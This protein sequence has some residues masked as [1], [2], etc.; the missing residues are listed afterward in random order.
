LKSNG[1][2]HSPPPLNPV[3]GTNV[4]CTMGDSVGGSKMVCCDVGNGVGSCSCPVGAGETLG[5]GD[6]D[7]AGLIVGAGEILGSG[8]IDGAAL[9]V[10][11]AEILGAF[12]MDGGS[13]AGSNTSLGWVEGKRLG[14]VEDVGLDVLVLGALEIEGG[15]VPWIGASLGCVDGILLGAIDTEGDSVPCIGALL[16]LGV[17]DSLG[18]VEE[19]GL[20]VPTT[21]RM[22]L[23][24]PDGD[25][26]AG[27]CIPLG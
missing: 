11:A 6:V 12:D 21:G 26:V 1:S 7:G 4:I 15:I 27:I 9:V 19:L 22:V 2:G 24:E 10:C 3:V 20:D 8:D 16:G 14:C 17:G 13:V 18:R 25:S 5:R 23:G